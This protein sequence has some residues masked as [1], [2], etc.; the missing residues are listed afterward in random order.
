[1]DKYD[2]INKILHKENKDMLEAIAKE[3]FPDS[4][5]DQAKFINKYLKVN[6]CK[7]KILSKNQK[8]PIKYYDKTVKNLRV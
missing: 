1:M 6:Y 5:E 3:E 2:L 7:L 4:L 8:D